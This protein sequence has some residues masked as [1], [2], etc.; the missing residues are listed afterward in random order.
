MR[1]GG[2]GP[3]GVATGG[4]AVEQRSA[5]HDGW[6]RALYGPSSWLR[7]APVV[8]LAVAGLCVSTDLAFFQYGLVTSVWDP[9]F[10]A[11]SRAVLT[12]ALSRALPV[13]DA[14]LGAAAYLVEAVLEAAGGTRRWQ[15]RPWLVLLLGLTAATMAVTSIGLILVQATVVRQFCTLCLASAGI[16]LVVPFLVVHEVPTA[17]RQVRR[18]RSLGLPW[19]LAVLG[20][21]PDRYSAT[22]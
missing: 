12:S 4:V 7:R 1:A 18:G 13:H 16:S 6:W 3:G 8:V 22:A 5:G 17:L 2:V 19:H 11:G 14:A 20:R 10:G 9:F 21:V 15:S